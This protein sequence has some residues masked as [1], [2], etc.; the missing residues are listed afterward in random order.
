MTIRNQSLG[1]GQQGVAIVTVLLILAI[2]AVTSVSYLQRQQVTVVASSQLLHRGQVRAHLTGVELWVSQIL[3]QDQQ[4]SD[5]DHLQEPWAGVLPVATV[6]QGQLM[7]QLVDLQGRYNLNNLRYGQPDQMIHVQYLQGL[8]VQLGL[9]PELAW[10]LLD[11]VDNNGETQQ[12]QLLEDSIYMQGP[13]PYRSAN[14]PLTDVSELNLIH[15]WT[16]TELAVLSPLIITLPEPTRIN[17]N[18]TEPQLIAALSDQISLVQAEALLAQQTTQSWP[19]P[20][21]FIDSLTQSGI[22]LESEDRQRITTLTSTQ[23]HYFELQAQAQISNTAEQLISR[24]KRLDDGS[25]KVLSRQFM[26]AP[27]L[28]NRPTP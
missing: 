17:I 6:E 2:I 10:P 26:P 19:N 8:L 21:A 18:T 12:G 1:L 5:T 9:D 27:P 28:L 25:L 22:N 13:S 4:D 15:N 23:S 24:F 20:D 7:G 3:R 14:Q 11:W 16:T